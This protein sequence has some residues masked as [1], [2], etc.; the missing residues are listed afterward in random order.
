MIDTNLIKELTSLSGISG[1]EDEVRDF[2]F[3]KIEG[4]YSE[5]TVDALGNLIILKKGKNPRKKPFMV[6]AHMDEVGLIIKDITEEGYLIFDTV[7]GI[8]PR[9]LIG[10]MFTI[11]EKKVKGIIST[12]AIHLFTSAERANASKATDLFIDIGA[13]SK[14]EA[15]AIVSRGDFVAFKNY[16]LEFGSSLVRAKALDDRLGCAIMIELI[17]QELPYDTYFTFTTQEEVGLRGAYT[18]ANR[19]APARALVIE[20]TT[21]ADLPDIK[22]A[23]KCCMLG[24][25][26]VISLADGRTIYPEKTRNNIVMLAEKNNI[27]WQYRTS[28]NGGNDAGAIHTALEGCE[29]AAISVPVR[30]IHSPNCVAH[31]NDISAVY[32]LA[33]AIIFQEEK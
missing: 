17:K 26:A 33:K 19:I 31:K 8:D 20:G 32:N 23:Q 6:A 30:Y 9:V 16:F 5:K 15:E 3:K 22:G 4:F 11:N 18:A 29:I 12:K 28:T 1:Y 27:E 13:G 7:G 21:A 14:G 25:G 10:K 2:I 24:K